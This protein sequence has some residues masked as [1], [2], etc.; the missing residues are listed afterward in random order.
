MAFFVIPFIAIGALLRRFWGGWDLPP[1]FHF[2]KIGIAAG[3][4][5]SIG[6]VFF[7]PIQIIIA[8]GLALILIF[9]NPLHSQGQEMGFGEK[10]NLTQSICFMSGSYAALTLIA[11]TLLWFI[12][13]SPLQLIY[14]PFGALAS[15]GY[16]LGWWVLPKAFGG[17]NADHGYNKQI[18]LFGNVLIDGPTSIG[19]LFLGAV[20]IGGLALAESF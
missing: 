19:E 12:S 10:Y 7:E 3:A 15:I 2:I 1:H 11:A 20:I 9:L 6:I 13:G 16:I 4:G 17:F 5:I 18:K 8:L 14:A